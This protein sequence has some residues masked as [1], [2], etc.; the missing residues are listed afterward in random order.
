MRNLNK[1]LI[2]FLILIS[3]DLYSQ[4]EKLNILDTKMKIDSFLEIRS[5]DSLNLMEGIEGVAESYE[6]LTLFNQLTNDIYR[7]FIRDSKQNSYVEFTFYYKNNDLILAKVWKELKKD[8]L[9]IDFFEQD[10]YYYNENCIETS[11]DKI[12]TKELLETGM[13]YLKKDYNFKGNKAE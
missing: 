9:A 5:K 7:I 13:S 6:K 12:E 10:S 4:N 11:N 2:L 1:I 3:S 8:R